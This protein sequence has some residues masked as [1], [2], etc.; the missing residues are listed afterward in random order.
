[1]KF[2]SFESKI[3]HFYL[4]IGSRKDHRVLF[5]SLAHSDSQN[6]ILAQPKINELNDDGD[7]SVVNNKYKF[8]NKR[9]NKSMVQT[10]KIFTILFLILLLN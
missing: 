10:N 7:E 1:M 2:A 8:R 6:E 4:Q 5:F 3:E 9:L